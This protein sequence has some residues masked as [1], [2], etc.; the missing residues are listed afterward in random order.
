MASRT[1]VKNYLAQWMQ[2]GKGVSLSAH[3]KEIHI[4][5]ILQ[6]ERY[7]PQFNQLWE[8][9]ST[10]K[11]QEAYLSGTNQT[12]SELLDNHWEII[13]CA[14]CNLLVPSLDLGA[15]VPVCCPCD[16]L[17]NHPNLDSVT[18]HVPVALA[19]RLDEICDRISKG[20][21]DSSNHQDQSDPSEGNYSSEEEDRHTIHNLKTSILKLVKTDKSF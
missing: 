15:R 14:R 9:I 5:K 19:D 13:A 20:A 21:S 17:P 18:P 10:T 1:L 8:D 3:G 4:G 2:M 7:S 11:A 16:D 6:G 12:I